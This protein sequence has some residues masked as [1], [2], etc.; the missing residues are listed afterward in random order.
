ML[1]DVQAAVYSN[2]HSVERFCVK[3]TSLSTRLAASALKPSLSNVSMPQVFIESHM[4]DWST[5][6]LKKGPGSNSVK[7]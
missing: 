7:S 4:N 2:V 6:Y 5:L 1:T 3:T